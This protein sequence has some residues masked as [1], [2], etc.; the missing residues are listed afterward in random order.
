MRLYNPG[1]IVKSVFGLEAPSG[2][3]AAQLQA[4]EDRKAKAERSR[5]RAALAAQQGRQFALR[6][7]AGL[8]DPGGPQ[9]ATKQLLGG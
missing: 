7:G 4:A 6:A 8:G 3:S 9:G 1:D 2:P 5:Q